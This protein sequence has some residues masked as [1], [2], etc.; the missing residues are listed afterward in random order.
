LTAPKIEVAPFHF[1][2][3]SNSYEPDVDETARSIKVPG[4][5]SK[6][7]PMEKPQSSP[8]K[9]TIYEGKLLYKEV[10]LNPVSIL[11]TI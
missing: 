7:T 9:P 3:P 4:L 2:G 11:P 8:S 6:V 5:D 10:F 1:I